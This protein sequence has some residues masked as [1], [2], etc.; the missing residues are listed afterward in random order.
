MAEKTRMTNADVYAKV[1][2]QLIAEMEKGTV[3]WGRPWAGGDGEH[4][5]AATGRRYNGLNMLA[6]DVTA[7]VRGYDLPGWLTFNQALKHECVV[8]KGEKATPVFY[9]NR[10]T[11]KDRENPDE[12][13]TFF[14]ARLFSVFN[15]AQ[16]KDRE[17]GSGAHAKLLARLGATR[18]VDFD[19]VAACEAA[20]ARLKDSGCKVLH[21]GDR[22][23][24]SPALDRIQ[25]PP[26][27]TF[28]KG[29]GAYYP[30]L[31]HEAG[32]ATGH[33]SRLART[34]GAR[35]GDDAYAAE[36]LV[37]ELTAA[38]LCRRLGMEHVSQAASYLDHWLTRLRKDP[39]MLTTAASAAAKA[40]EW[41]YPHADAPTPDD[42]EEGAG[43][44]VEA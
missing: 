16:L 38:F 24:Y 27:K 37:A 17:P 3:P 33:E 10:I 39:G 25:M 5:N 22:A 28:P 41:L 8:A 23:S 32:H 40:A 4:R 15:V 29:P 19:P 35:F 30:V 11:R 42:A 2:A 20:V 21:G 14:L 12:S 44:L 26:R 13:Q 18:P 1:T 34:F 43:E 6:L 7:M 9:M 36:E 31:F